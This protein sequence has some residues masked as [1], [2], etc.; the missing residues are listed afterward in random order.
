MADYPVSG[1]KAPA[2]HEHIAAAVWRSEG[3][4]S[5]P[6]FSIADRKTSSRSRCNIIC[7][8]TGRPCS[9]DWRWR[10]RNCWPKRFPSGR[11]SFSRAAF[12]DRRRSRFRARPS[13]DRHRQQARAGMAFGHKRLDQPFPRHLRLHGNAG[14]RCEGWCRYRK[15]R[16]GSGN[17]GHI[18]A[19]PRAAGAQ[20][21]C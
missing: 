14:L 15:N 2:M 3:F 18:E 8:S 5:G 16:A 11:R 19:R 12:W 4:L 17:G 10:C 1:L 13:A 20:A 21:D 9:T 7:H 6:V